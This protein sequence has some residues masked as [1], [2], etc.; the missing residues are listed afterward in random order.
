MNLEPAASNILPLPFVPT[1]KP[2][3]QPTLEECRFHAKEIDL[4]DVE[5]QKFYHYFE[6]KGWRVGRDPMRVWRSAM[7]GW[8]LRHDEHEQVQRERVDRPSK[9]V[10]FIAWQTELQRVEA[11]MGSIKGSYS[12]HQG[13]SVPDKQLFTKLK[14]RRDE[15]VKNLGMI[16]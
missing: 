10:Q 11:K 1:A 16:L 3:R 9:S 6:S 4:S 8:K 15:L 12:E 5:A 2:M 13:W 14:T 7:A